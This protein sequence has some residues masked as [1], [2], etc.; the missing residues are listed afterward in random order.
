M[1]K[2]FKV[3]ILL[4]I[5][6]LSPVVSQNMLQQGNQWIFE[7]NEGIFGLGQTIENITV[8]D[9]T[10]INQKNYSRL[11]ATRTFPC[12]IFASIEFLREEG[13]KIF[14]LSRDHQQEFLMIDFDE[15]VGYEMLYQPWNDDIDTGIVVID[16][17][18]IEFAAD[19][20]P[21]E[22]QYMKIINNQSFDDEQPYKV[23]RDIGFLFPGFLFP[24]L[25]TG[26]CDPFD[27]VWP[28][29]HISDQDTIHF[30]EFDCYE[31]SI[32][33]GTHDVKVHDVKLYPNPSSDR[34]VIPSGLI[35]MD[36]TSID[37]QVIKPYI[38][39]GTVYLAGLPSGLY[40][41]RFVS[42]GGKEIYVG[43]VVKI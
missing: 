2:S 35:F 15:T 19:N 23:Y 1:N 32:I 8:G 4:L 17:F 24:D 39:E 25:G 13:N 5:A 40:I 30:T 42:S 21:I 27:W 22:V 29:C 43:G 18:G 16:S 7:Y 36:M 20:T 11:T 34:V 12:E 10:L 3:L 26:L 6:H 14:R 9:D 28:R 33:D 31:S 38:D 41:L 37:G